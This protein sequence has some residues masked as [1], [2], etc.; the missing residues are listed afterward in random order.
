MSAT[1][2]RY[3]QARPAA[4]CVAPAT[5]P[6]LSTPDCPTAPRTRSSPE[7]SRS[8]VDRQ[9]ETRRSDPR[10]PTQPARTISSYR[11]VSKASALSERLRSLYRA[12]PE[13]TS[14]RQTSAHSATSPPATRIPHR[15]S[16]P[17]SA[18]HHGRRPLGC[19]ATRAAAIA[20]KTIASLAALTSLQTCAAENVRG[21]SPVRRARSLPYQPD[22]PARLLHAPQSPVPETEAELTAA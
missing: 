12:A 5:L 6:F 1:T 9:L 4:A 10:R 3:P 20:A 17:S 21:S 2:P 18:H 13:K 16:P 7:S 11:A 14:R 22:A 19:T 8:S 15:R